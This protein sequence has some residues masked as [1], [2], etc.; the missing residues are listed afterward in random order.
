MY[1]V[2][3]RD[4]KYLETFKDF[5]EKKK[6]ATCEHDNITRISI[7]W[8]N[9]MTALREGRKGCLSMENCSWSG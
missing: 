6:R 9:N 4:F 5:F 2:I 3:L 1:V 8:R 7:N